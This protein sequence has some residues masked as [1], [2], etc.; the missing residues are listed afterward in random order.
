MRGE[1]EVLLGRQEHRGVALLVQQVA[2]FIVVAI[3]V[4]MNSVTRSRE[5]N[6][7]ASAGIPAQLATCWLLKLGAAATLGKLRPICEMK[8]L[9]VMVCVVKDFR[10]HGRL[11][12]LLG[13]DHRGNITIH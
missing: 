1:G 4:L 8:I 10:R 11:K 9:L 3:F 7:E 6:M 5:H 13:L 2:F 12:D